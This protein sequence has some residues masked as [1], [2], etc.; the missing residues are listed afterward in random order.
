MQMLK[1]K[2][3]VWNLVVSEA[4]NHNMTRKTSKKI[5]FFVSREKKHSSFAGTWLQ[6][7]KNKK[8]IVA[9]S[10]SKFI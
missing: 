6:A 2:K 1:N 5:N 8:T 3:N 7:D 9:N 10:I 4:R